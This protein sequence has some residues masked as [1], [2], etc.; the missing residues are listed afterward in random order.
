MKWTDYV[1]FAVRNES[2]ALPEEPS[3]VGYGLGTKAHSRFRTYVA[4]STFA[5]EDFPGVLTHWYLNAER[6]CFD[7]MS[8]NAPVVSRLNAEETAAVLDRYL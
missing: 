7:I 5:D 1:A 3:P 2:F 6:H 4:A 8:V